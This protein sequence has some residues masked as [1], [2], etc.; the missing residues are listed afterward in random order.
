MKK[1]L[2]IIFAFFAIATAGEF[3]NPLP[4]PLPATYMELDPS[5]PQDTSWYTFCNWNIVVVAHRKGPYP[6]RPEMNWTKV[7]ISFEKGIYEYEN[8]VLTMTTKG[9]R[10]QR[11]EKSGKLY[12]DVVHGLVKSYERPR[13]IS[14]N[15]FKWNT[16]SLTGTVQGLPTYISLS[17]WN[18]KSV[19]S[20]N[21][22]IFWLYTHMNYDA[23][24]P[25]TPPKH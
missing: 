13:P 14:I 22:P 9:S 21:H 3:V 16:N 6:N 25:P 8:G 4:V 7:F 5:E 17:K 15:I 1:L 2:A 11:W 23:S 10:P 24:V 19:L 20:Y 18:G 12:A